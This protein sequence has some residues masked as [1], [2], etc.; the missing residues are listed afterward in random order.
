[1]VLKEHLDK[2]LAGSK[3]WEIRGKAT[4]IRGP[5]ALIESKSGEVVGVCDVVDVAGPLSLAELNRNERRTGF[6]TRKLPYLA[7]YA[8]VLR[9]A[10]RLRAP[11]PYRHPS[12]AVVWV[13]LA[14]AVIEK[15]P[16]V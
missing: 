8:W 13:K 3:T 15:L 5:I 4:A 12:G 9:N 2:I 1:L 11:V 16:K 7:T 10:R 6:R 14:P